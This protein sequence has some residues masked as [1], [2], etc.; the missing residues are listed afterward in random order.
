MAVTIKF[1]N[2]TSRREAKKAFLLIVVGLFGVVVLTGFTIFGFFYF[3]YQGIVDER[4]KQRIF[5]N[6]AKIYA[7]PREIRP[8]QKLSIHLVVNDLRSAGYTTDGA[9]QSSPMAPIAKACRQSR[10]SRGRS[11]ITRLTRRRFM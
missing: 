1:A 11:R 9:S 2:P 6:T 3:K 10:Y 8:G 7:A 4:L 5:A